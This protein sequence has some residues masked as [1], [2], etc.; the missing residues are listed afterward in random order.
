MCEESQGYRMY[1]SDAIEI[2]NCAL[3]ILS[4]TFNLLT[5]LSTYIQDFQLTYKTFN[6]PTRHKP[7]RKLDFQQTYNTLN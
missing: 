3:S 4:K 2:L 1:N 5:R 6:L 7:D